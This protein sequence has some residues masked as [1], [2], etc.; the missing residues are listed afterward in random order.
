MVLLD[1]FFLFP[2]RPIDRLDSIMQLP[3]ISSTQARSIGSLQLTYAWNVANNGPMGL[4]F[5]VPWNSKAN[6]F[7][8]ISTLSG[9]SGLDTIKM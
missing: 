3:E 8:V 1:R 4:F 5:C 2:P 7:P 9:T 6:P